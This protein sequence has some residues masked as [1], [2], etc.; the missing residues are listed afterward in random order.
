MNELNMEKKQRESKKEGRER[1][2]KIKEKNNKE[3][4]R[5]DERDEHRQKRGSGKI[6]SYQQLKMIFKH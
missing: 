1:K 4:M 2:G 6:V 5:V 3:K